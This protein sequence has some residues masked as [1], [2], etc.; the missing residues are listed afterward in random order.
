M[1]IANRQEI[2]KIHMSFGYPESRHEFWNRISSFVG[3]H[4]EMKHANRDMWKRNFF[5][6]LVYHRIHGWLSRQ[7][8]AEQWEKFYEESTTAL[9]QTLAKWETIDFIINGEN[10]KCLCLERMSEGELAR[11]EAVRLE[12][13]WRK[14]DYDRPVSPEYGSFTE[15]EVKERVQTSTSLEN[16]KRM[17]KYLYVQANVCSADGR[18]NMIGV[19]GEWIFREATGAGESGRQRNLNCTS[20]DGKT[21]KSH[22]VESILAPFEGMP[23]SQHLIHSMTNSKFA[24]EGTSRER[25]HRYRSISSLNVTLLISTVEFF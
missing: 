11:R 14:M 25:S 20:E 21:G 18:R 16:F 13:K 15:G 12:D 8:D 23:A 19:L 4:N 3:E 7:C 22:V 2:K 5:K 24:H 6:N 10:Q 9:L 1:S 17:M